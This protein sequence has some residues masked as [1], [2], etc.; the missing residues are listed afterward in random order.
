LAV[1]AFEMRKCHITLPV[2][3]SSYNAEAILKISAIYLQRPIHFV[4]MC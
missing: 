3:K 2:P 1:E 4:K